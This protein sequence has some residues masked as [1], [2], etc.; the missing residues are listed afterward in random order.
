MLPFANEVLGQI[1]I[2]GKLQKAVILNK[3]QRHLLSQ[4]T[5]EIEQEARDCH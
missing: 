4:Q 3:I 1:D 2:G 5:E